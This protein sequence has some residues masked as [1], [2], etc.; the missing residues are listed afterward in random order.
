MVSMSGFSLVNLMARQTVVM[1]DL[2]MVL[3]SEWMTVQVM[4]PLRAG[5]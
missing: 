5:N 4:E 3:N 2:K 1:K